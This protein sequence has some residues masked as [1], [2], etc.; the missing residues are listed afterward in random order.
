MPIMPIKPASGGAAPTTSLPWTSITAKPTF[1]AVSTTGAYSDLSGK[2]TTV[3]AAGL[4][5]AATMPWCTSNFIT[6]SAL[7]PYATTASLAGYATT[8]ALS[9]KFNTPA[10]TT[11]QYIRGDGSLAAFPGLFDGTYASLTGK[12]TLATVATSGSYSDLSNRPTIVSV[13]IGTPVTKGALTLATAYQATDNTKPTLVT[14]SITSTSSI[15]LSGTS[16]NEGAIWIGSTNAVA[17]GTGTRLAEYKNSLGGGLVVGLTI[18]TA[19]TQPYS[20]VLP[21]GW[22]YAVRQTVGTGMTVVSAFDQS[23]T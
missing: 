15:S 16:N 13:V 12:P 14:L 4:T 5:D 8:G 21:I 11:S 20:F 9:G 19:Q 2:P 3:S 18:T 22:Y 23:L 7:T 17:S 1:A 10:G 6:A